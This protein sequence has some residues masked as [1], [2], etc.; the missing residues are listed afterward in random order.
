M[1]R[2]ATEEDV[3]FVLDS[4]RQSYATSDRALEVTPKE[5]DR[6]EQCAACGGWRLRSTA[7]H[8]GRR[9]SR[10]GSVY[11]SGQRSLILRLVAASNTSVVETDVGGR[12][13]LD[14]FVCR[15]RVSA[16]LH[17][18]FVRASARR[19]GLARELVADLLD[20]PTRYT[21]RSRGLQGD[22]LP[23]HWVYDPYILMV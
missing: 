20:R 7:G 10:A 3:P 23:K 12:P 19:H 17:Y 6:C 14:G 9:H 13:M 8:D 21:H 2:L 16:V 4:W 11:W 22:R 15:D 5:P 1:I 18:V